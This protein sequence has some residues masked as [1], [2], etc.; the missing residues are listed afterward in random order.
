MAATSKLPHVEV[1]EC[2]EQKLQEECTDSVLR[3]LTDGGNVKKARDVAGLGMAYE[4][5]HV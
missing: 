2:E 3:Q 1:E 5:N 4:W